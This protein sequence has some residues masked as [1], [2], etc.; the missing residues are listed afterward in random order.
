ML[1]KFALL[2]V[3]F[4]NGEIPKLLSYGRR[5]NDKPSDYFAF[6]RTDNILSTMKSPTEITFKLGNRTQGIISVSCRRFPGNKAFL[7][8]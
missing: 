7:F 8:K 5:L 3:V 6:C 1:T 2:R 4:T